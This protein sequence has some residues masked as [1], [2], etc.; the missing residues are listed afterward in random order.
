MIYL[1]RHGETRYNL[2]GRFLG[3]T[4]IGL[5]EQGRVMFESIAIQLRQKQITAIYCSEYQRSRES[6]KILSAELNIPVF[7]SKDLG[8]RHLGVFDGQKKSDL[9]GGAYL[10]KLM[11]LNFTPPR[12]ESGAGCLNRFSNA[13]KTIALSVKGN[14]VVISHGGAIAL[15]SRYVLNVPQHCA[16]L[17]PGAFHLLMV[18]NQGKIVGKKF[19]QEFINPIAGNVEKYKY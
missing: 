1:F 8:E 6:A 3:Q 16:F 13:F 7:V 12:G 2:E 14:I 15:Y 17:N 18:N 11:D 10:S 19:N 4:D 5:L 9:A